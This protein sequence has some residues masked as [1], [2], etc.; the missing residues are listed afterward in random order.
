MKDYW[1]DSIIVK[2][3]KMNIF[4]K[5]KS[6]F[7]K[8]NKAIWHKFDGVVKKDKS[9]RFRYYIYI[10]GKLAKMESTFSFWYGIK[11]EESDI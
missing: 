10:D 7:Q 1:I 3:S 4:K 5:I 6:I 8:Q 9:G 11:E 2:G